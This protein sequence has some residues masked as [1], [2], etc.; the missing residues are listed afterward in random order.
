[1]KKTLTKS[2]LSTL[3]LLCLC[4]VSGELR[5]Q[6]SKSDLKKIKKKANSNTYSTLLN[7]Y[8]QNDTTLT[9]DDYRLLY[10]GEAFRKNFKPYSNHD[11]VKVLNKHL[12]KNSD[13]ADYNKIINLCLQ[14]L[15]DYPFNISELYTTA[16][17]YHAIEETELSNIYLHKYDKLIRTILYSGDGF[18]SNSAFV[19]CKIRDEYSLLRALKLQSAGQR[20]INIKSRPYDLIQLQENELGI[21]EFYFD[22]HLFFGKQF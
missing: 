2:I 22:I 15:E 12:N 5:A 7:R 11:S 16:V 21:T 10:Y 18:E 9:P 1:M 19:V 4:F 13:S 20:L 3:L 6:L 17:A 14:I 8:R